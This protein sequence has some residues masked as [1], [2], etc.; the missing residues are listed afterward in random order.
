MLGLGD[1]KTY[2]SYVGMVLLNSECSVYG[3]MGNEETDR[4]PRRWHRMLWQHSAGRDNFSV[5]AL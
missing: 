2:F 5:P 1:R 3:G 4:H